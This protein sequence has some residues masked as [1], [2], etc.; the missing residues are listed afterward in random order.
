MVTVVPCWASSV[1]SSTAEV[2]FPAPPLELAKE[3][4]GMASLFIP[5]N[6][7]LTTVGRLLIDNRLFANCRQIDDSH[8]SV[9]QLALIGQLLT[10][11]ILTT[12]AV[13]P[14]EPW[15]FQG[16]KARHHRAKA[17]TLCALSDSRSRPPVYA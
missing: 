15:V 11:D 1:A 8:P 13:L 3:M 5:N 17:M 10:V 6:H 7:V 2:D 14:D 16:C 9:C 4:V 12:T